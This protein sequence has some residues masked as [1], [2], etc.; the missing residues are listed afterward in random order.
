MS[1]HPGPGYAAILIFVKTTHNTTTTISMP[2]FLARMPVRHTMVGMVA[3]GTG[4]AAATAASWQHQSTIH[5]AEGGEVKETI[6]TSSTVDSA[7]PS[8]AIGPEWLLM[9]GALW[10]MPKMIWL[11]ALFGAEVNKAYSATFND[12]L[13]FFENDG[14]AYTPLVAACITGNTEAVDE[15]LLV[16]A[17]VN[18]ADTWI[19]DVP[20]AQPALYLAVQYQKKVRINKKI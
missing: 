9:K 5:Q 13:M 20:M 6:L 3:A 12:D 1:D 11:G 4:I 19:A 18:C 8:I 7:K 2:F 10:G 15:L 16:G 14:S 17:D